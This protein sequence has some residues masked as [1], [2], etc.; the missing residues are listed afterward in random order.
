MLVSAHKDLAES[1]KTRSIVQAILSG[2]G[3]NEGFEATG[4]AYRRYTECL[5]PWLET[6]RLRFEDELRRRAQEFSRYVIEISTTED[7]WKG[8]GPWMQKRP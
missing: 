1:A 4:R 5:T 6:E 2:P 7:A 8:E 3:S